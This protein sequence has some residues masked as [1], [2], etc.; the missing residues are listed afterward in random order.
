MSL[1]LL[2][3]FASSAMLAV[4]LQRGPAVAVLPAPNAKLDAEFT[5]IVAVRELADGRVLVSDA[6]ERKLFLADFTSGAVSVIGQEGQGPGEYRSVGQ[7]FALAGDSTLLVDQIG[8]RWLQLHGARIVQTVGADAP[9]IR[10][11]FRVPNGVDMRGFV[12]GT[13]PMGAVAGA[14]AL[15]MPPRMDSSHLV[16][17]SRA[18]GRADT[19]AALMSRPARI[20]TQGTA[21]TTTMIEITTNPLAAGDLATMFGD[22]TG[23]IARVAPY[24]VDWITADG[25]LTRGGALPFTRVNVTAR[26]KEAVLKRMA[27]LSGRAS[28]PH[29]SI[30]DW[31]EIF[32]PFTPGALLPAPDGRLWIRRTQ[33]VDAPDIR[34]DVITRTG[35]LALKLSMPPNEQVVGFGRGV[36]FTVQVDDDGIQHLRRHPM[37]R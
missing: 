31:P 9:A 1:P 2:R 3:G 28:Q 23:A 35:T 21:N 6:G 30:P 32:P 29:E 20:R 24:R 4:L 37:P 27:A 13:R 7:L 14:A 16:R 5:R 11:G 26:E 10:G 33:S 19:I 17:V 22:G 36:V 25:R 34:Y 15:S 18:T 12:L 8:A